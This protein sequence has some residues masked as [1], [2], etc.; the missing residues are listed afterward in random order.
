MI[1]QSFSTE[2]FVRLDCDLKDPAGELL[3]PGFWID[4]RKNL[5]VGERMALVDALEA[6]DIEAN[7]LSDHYLELG[8]DLEAQKEAAQAEEKPDRSLIRSLDREAQRMIRE[9]RRKLEHIG[10]RRRELIVPHIRAWNLCDG[11]GTP[12]PAPRD[13]GS[14]VLQTAF[15]DLVV[16]M[17]ITVMTAYR[18]GKALSTTISSGDAQVPGQEQNVSG[19]QVIDTQ[20]S[21]RSRKKS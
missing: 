11:D 18:L 4:A 7:D 17:T 14:A 20:P 2:Q 12:I 15:P 8:E 16:W 9:Y 19:P 1:T 21:R 6:L 3:Y 13:G 10:E 5:T